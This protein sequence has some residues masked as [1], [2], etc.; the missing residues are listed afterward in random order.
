MDDPSR[1]EVGQV[2]QPVRPASVG[3][4][5][6]PAGDQERRDRVALPDRGGRHAAP[7]PDRPRLHLRPL[8]GLLGL[9]LFMVAIGILLIRVINQS[10]EAVDK[11]GSQTAPTE[12]LPPPVA[13]GGFA[14]AGNLLRNWSFEQD[15]EGWQRVGSARLTRELGGRTSGSSAFVQAAATGPSRVGI[16]APDIVQVRR[17][18]VY[19]ATAW[20]RSG[21]PGM[22][23]TVALVVNGQG[24]REAAAE[25]AVTASDPG[26]VRVDVEHRAKAGGVLSLEVTL[27]NAKLGEGLLVDEVIVHQA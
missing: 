3:A 15:T 26:W 23:V 17:G 22:R 1:A 9:V 13:S 8:I 24:G 20:V 12:Q 4:K 6:G 5:P 19:D 2:T 25:R 7:Q 16:A 18:E 11:G 21:T 10:Q 27:E 14:A